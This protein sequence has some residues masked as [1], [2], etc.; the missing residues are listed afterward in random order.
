ME[1]EFELL[2]KLK[3]DIKH[4]SKT[5][6]EQEARFL[7][8]L[9]YQ[10]QKFR[11]QT[12]NQIRILTKDD[13]QESHETLRFFNEQYKKLENDIQA[14]LKVYAQ[15]KQIGRW[16]M[17]ICGIGPV[18]AAGF[19]AHIDIN[20]AETAGAIWRFAGLDPTLPPMKKGVKLA[21]NKKLKV[22][23][24]HPDTMI[25]VK[26]GYKAIKDIEVGEYVLTHKGN[27]KK[28]T[29]K[30]VNDCENNEL[31]ELS[32]FG[33]GMSPLQVT[34]Y[35]PIYVT[36]T[37]T[38]EVNKGGRKSFTRGKNPTFKISKIDY[39]NILEQHS[40]GAT[41]TSLASKYGVSLAYISNLV[42]G[43]TK[44]ENRYEESIGWLAA[45]Q[46]KGG[47]L[48]LA[49]KPL[50]LNQDIDTITFEAEGAVTNEGGEIASTG[51]WENTKAPRAK[52]FTPN[53]P[54]N[55]D[56]LRLFGLFIAEGHVSHNTIGFGFNIKEEEYMDFVSKQVK[57]LFNQEC[58]K[59]DNFEQNSSQLTFVN[60]IV[61]S[62]FRRLFGDDS[63]S[64]KIPDEFMNL[65][66]EKIKYLLKGLFEGDGTLNSKN[67]QYTTVSKT[68][69][70]QVY[71]ILTSLGLSTRITT[72]EKHYK[73][74]VSD[75]S[76]FLKRIFDKDVKDERVHVVYKRNDE[77]GT[78][79]QFRMPRKLDYNG[80]VYNLEVEE[81]NSY[82]ANGI[83]VHN[84]WKLGQSFVKVSN[85]DK[86]IYGHI[87]RERKEYEIQRNE[88][89]ENAEI[90]KQA[91]EKKNYRKD[92]EAYKC[93]SRGILPPA[94]IQA[95]AE[96]YAV[97]I[98][99]SH[100]FD[101]WY[102]LERGQEPP[103]PFAIGILGHAH[104]I[105]P[106]PMVA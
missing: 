13:E 103:K 17:S 55:G 30:F 14:C 91:L 71:D 24:C 12:G 78:W 5:M 51:R 52:Y 77:D 19:I 88:A 80:Q 100:L 56:T 58:K 43:K 33:H 6:K 98:F 45:G 37:K 82:I 18:I 87:Y 49:V 106:P 64:R 86:D 21:W 54:I 74:N 68:L 34:S 75:K 96:R 70:Y 76:D 3:K 89:G 53:I 44:I 97:K 25:R 10:I 42:N 9:Y 46:V 47:H 69:A 1:L 38:Y 83:A 72:N 36:K 67:L 79:Y 7:V 50:N 65:P 85:N 62:N 35:H 23:C 41:L 84:C 99:L 101:V 48:G 16:M 32:L 15:S 104:M 29:K 28:V 66:E 11:I 63:H 93:Y 4:A 94:H 61:A 92:T 81:D 60:K 31:V 73:I 40:K 8:D 59:R 39:E 105:T 57:A 27:Y 20:K 22:L 90:A 102:R 95:R 26:D 2:E